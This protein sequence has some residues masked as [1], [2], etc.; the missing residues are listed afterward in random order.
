MFDIPI[1]SIQQAKEYFKAMGCSH[2]HMSREYPERYKEYEKLNISKS[3][4]AEWREEEVDKYYSCILENK[5]NTNLWWIHSRIADLVESLKT[6]RVLEKLVEVTFY[7]RDR[8][9]YKDRVMVSETINGRKDRKY[10][11][12]LIYLAYDLHEIPMAKAFA[13]LSLHF[14]TYSDYKSQEIKR[15]EAS[16]KLCN[17]IK[18]DLDL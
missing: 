17:E 1:D 9:P 13:E 11:S 8:V 4:E 15:Y 14:S 5:D 3:K 2:F 16:A 7:I 12:G 6:R 10:R 18:H